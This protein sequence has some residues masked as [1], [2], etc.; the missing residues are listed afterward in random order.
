MNWLAS[1][2]NI[3]HIFAI[4]FAG[5]AAWYLTPQGQQIIQAVVAAYP[6]LSGVVTAL[7]FIVALYHSPKP[8]A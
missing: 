7:G 4:I 3:T 8:G 6:K 5:V 2:K 1:F